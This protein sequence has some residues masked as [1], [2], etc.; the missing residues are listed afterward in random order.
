MA[1]DSMSGAASVLKPEMV[2]AVLVAR[3]EDP[4]SVSTQKP[5][6]RLPPQPQPPVVAP[7]IRRQ[8]Q[9]SDQSETIAVV[10]LAAVLAM[11]LIIVS[12]G[13]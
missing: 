8:Q 7:A 3:G 12:S 1:V 11:G 9:K 6:S 2:H 10:L 5:V 4:P 13:S